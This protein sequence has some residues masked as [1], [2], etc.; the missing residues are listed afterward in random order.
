MAKVGAVLLAA[1]PSVRFGTSNKLLANIRG[2][3]LIH[4]V[5]ETIVGG[6]AIAEKL[7]VTGFD[8]T[9]IERALRGLPVR[10]VANQ[11][12]RA[13]MGSSIAAG[14]ST[15]SADIEGALI[16]PGDMPLLTLGLVESLIAK[17]N[18]SGNRSIVFPTTLSGEQRNPVLWPRRYFPLLTSLRG[19]EGGK[20]LLAKLADSCVAVPVVDETQFLDIDEADD[21]A[22]VQRKSGHAHAP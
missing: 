19:H 16:V 18:E 15:L 20:Q 5:A 21:L 6:G 13:G 2:R 11:D 17:F 8:R 3:P 12:W 7:V 4:V 10:F 1:G 9:E 22:A 14:V